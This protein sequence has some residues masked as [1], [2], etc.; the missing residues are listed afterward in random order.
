MSIFPYIDE[1]SYKAESLPLYKDIKT[2]SEGLPV[3][4]DGEPV[5]VTGN[6]A[7]KTWCRY[8]LLT[9]RKRYAPLPWSYGSDVEKLIGKGYLPQ[10]TQSELTRYVRECLLQNPYIKSVSDIDITFRGNTL[11]GSFA[12]ITIYGEDRVDV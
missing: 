7:I 3:F 10:T 12:I 6:E 11:T 2:D 4:K 9:E 5:F 1:K 8:A